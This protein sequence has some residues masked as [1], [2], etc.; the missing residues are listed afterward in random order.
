MNSL[1]HHREQNIS[2]Y[3]CVR[4]LAEII[5]SRAYATSADPL[6]ISPKLHLGQDE[7]QEGSPFVAQELPA[8]FRVLFATLRSLQEHVGVLFAMVRSSQ[9]LRIWIFLEWDSREEHDNFD[10]VGWRS[11]TRIC[12]VR[13][14]LVG[15][16]PRAPPSQI[17]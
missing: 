7:L 13:S 17:G 5:D 1:K 11:E 12:M 8:P 4:I 2:E 14:D 9:K 15:C 10:R 3:Y 6:Q 16:G